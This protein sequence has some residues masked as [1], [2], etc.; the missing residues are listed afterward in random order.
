MPIIELDV[1]VY[2]E[3]CGQGICH[4][5]TVD[6]GTRLHIAPCDRCMAAAKEQGYDQGYDEASDEEQTNAIRLEMEV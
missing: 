6:R 5:V 3:E 1:E 2:C 4:L